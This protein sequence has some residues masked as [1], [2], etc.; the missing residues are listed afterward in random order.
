MIETHADTLHEFEITV[1]S[2]VGQS[3]EITVE[4]AND[5]I[6]A[7]IAE[8]EATYMMDGYEF[9]AVSGRRI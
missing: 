8:E 5:E 3:R 6:A 1:E 9:T 4:A 7:E 2:N